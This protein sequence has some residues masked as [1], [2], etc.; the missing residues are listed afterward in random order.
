MRVNLCNVF[1]SFLFL[2]INNLTNPRPLCRKAVELLPVSSSERVTRISF[3]K[4]RPRNRPPLNQN[5]IR[6]IFS[7][8]LFIFH[9]P[10]I[11]RTRYCNSTLEFQT[12]EARQHLTKNRSIDRRKFVCRR[13]A[14]RFDIRKV[15]RTRLH[16]EI[17]SRTSV[18]AFE[19]MEYIQRKKF[20]TLESYL[21]FPINK[22]GILGSSL[23][24]LDRFSQTFFFF[25]PSPLIEPRIR[26]D[27]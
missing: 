9:L 2:L 27:F 20:V 4:R 13:T 3:P 25:V 19:T 15:Q 16:V 24:R 8:H 21:F 5:N 1:P 10:R 12:Y 23:S 7:H 6:N 14:K 26:Y 22:R 11:A 17:F 18:H